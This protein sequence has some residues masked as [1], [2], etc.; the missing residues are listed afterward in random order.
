MIY[1][2]YLTSFNRKEKKKE[3]EDEDKIK[4]FYL[5]KMGLFCFFLLNMI[6]IF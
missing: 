1:V 4:V 3:E 2:Y 5:K 6:F